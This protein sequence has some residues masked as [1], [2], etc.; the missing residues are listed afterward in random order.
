GGKC[1]ITASQA[2]N[3]SFANAPDVPRAFTVAKVGQTITFGALPARAFGDPDFAVTA[4]ASSGLPVAFAASG[5]CTVAGSTVH[6]TAIGSCTVTASQPG[7]ASFNAAA[8]V[9]QT[10]AIAKGNQTISFGA[11]AAKT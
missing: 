6:L 2:G 9:P 5:N 4:T 7:N 1:T 3:A 11:L 8:D 10:F